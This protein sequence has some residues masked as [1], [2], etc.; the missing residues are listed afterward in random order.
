MPVAVFCFGE[1]KGITMSQ[2]IY[3]TAIEAAK[4]A[5]LKGFDHIVVCGA[6]LTFEYVHAGEYR[7]MASTGEI[8]RF[9]RKGATVTMLPA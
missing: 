4:R 3:A 8:A 5:L 7:V 6:L 1:R 2:K 9:V